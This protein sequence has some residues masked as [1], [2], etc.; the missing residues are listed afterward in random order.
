MVEEG[1]RF[2]LTQPVSAVLTE[3]LSQDRWS[4]RR[5]RD[6]SPQVETGPLVS[7]WQLE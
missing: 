6:N 5:R 2:G 7:L 1:K 4:A 3:S